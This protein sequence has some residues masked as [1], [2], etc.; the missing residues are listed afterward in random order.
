M[1]TSRRGL[2]SLGCLVMLLLAAAFIY[3]GVNIG[4]HYFR[5][6]QYQDAMRQEVKF[7]AHNSDALIL[8]HLRE[9]ADSLGLP[10]AAG[11]V[12]L[13]RDGRHIEVES[14]YYVHME[15][16]LIVREVRFSPHAE[17]IF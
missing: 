2:T 4:E 12:T 1:V 5:F 7:A 9:R 16:P 6:Y 11:E 8:R 3:F 14:E 17:G 15:L 10:E 13:Q